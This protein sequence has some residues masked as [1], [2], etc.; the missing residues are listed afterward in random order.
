MI[1]TMSN[2]KAKDESFGDSPTEASD[3]LQFVSF[4]VSGQEYGLDIMHIREIKAWNGTT[5]LPNSPD[6]MRGVINL[7]GSIVPVVDLGFCFNGRETI[8]TP[9]TVILIVF[10]AGAYMG[11]LVDAVSDIV[12]AKKSDISRIPE[13]EM[14]HG[15]PYFSGIYSIDGQL[16]AIVSLD[17]LLGNMGSAGP[18]RTASTARGDNANAADTF[19]I[20]M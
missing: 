14:D 6:F 20:R 9:A 17:N 13:V 3:L 11:L 18:T 15:N 2:G 8:A 5:R 19:S 4:T 1:A 7:R 16:M 10:A 12:T